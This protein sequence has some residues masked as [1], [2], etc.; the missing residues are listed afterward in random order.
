MSKKK[1]SS[2]DFLNLMDE[3]E[4]APEKMAFNPTKAPNRKAKKTK[5]KTKDTRLLGR[6]KLTPMQEEWVQFAV[7]RTPKFVKDIVASPGAQKIVLQL[8][9][10]VQLFIRW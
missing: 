3:Q 8:E 7:A 2:Q 5:A 10:T 1:I 6:Y 4:V 9:T